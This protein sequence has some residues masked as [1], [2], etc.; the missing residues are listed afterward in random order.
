MRAGDPL[1]IE[2]LWERFRPRLLGL[3]RSTLAGRWQRMTD[4]E[5]A[6]QSA[7]I[8][9]WQRAERGDFGDELN[10]DDLWNVLGV[11]TVRKALKHQEREL[12]QKRGGNRTSS[13]APLDAIAAPMSNR[14]MELTCTQMLELLDEELRAFALLRLMGNK[15]REIAVQL[16]CTERKV[17][18]KMQLIRTVWEAEVESWTE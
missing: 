5:D 10:R 3:A 15:N 12:A 14:E 9:F 7:F 2:H 6:L 17:E 18:R 1:A 4:A 8:A 13:N 16:G 11:I